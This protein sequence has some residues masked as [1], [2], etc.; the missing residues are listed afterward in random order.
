MRLVGLTGGIGSGKSTV[1]TI[2]AEHGCDVI[3]AD[4]IAREVVEPGQP[5]LGELAERFGRSIL[6]EDGR[7]DR[8][9]LA[10]LAF[11]DDVARAEL[12]R[13]THPHIAARIAE[14]V[15]RLAASEE[16][17]APRV[18][19]VDHPLLVETGQAARFEDVVVVLA[20][21]E[22]RVA[23]LRERGMDEADARRRV[24]VQADDAARR[25]VATHIV[26]NAGDLDA[27]RARVAEVHADLLAAARAQPGP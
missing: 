24:A 23:R 12:D 21:V 5:A 11:A 25:A 2:L 26:D 19:V 4:R 17:G 22:L 10:G 3:D 1:A 14:S 8:S 16:P 6:T 20:P 7:L 27:L 9:A 13:I 15:A 18:V